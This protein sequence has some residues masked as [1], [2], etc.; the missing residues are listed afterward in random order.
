MTRY[1]YQWWL[2]GRS[3]YQDILQLVQAQGGGTEEDVLAFSSLDFG[4]LLDELA[5]DDPR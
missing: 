5:L 2:D 4:E 1:R 3:R